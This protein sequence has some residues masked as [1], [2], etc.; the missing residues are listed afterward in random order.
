MKRLFI[1]IA[2]LLCGICSTK[3]IP[4]DPTPKKV[5]QPDGTSLTVL[6]RGDEHRHL[7]FT[8][9]G[10]PL[11]FN[12]KTKTY[13]Y[14]RLDGSK[15]TGSGLAAADKDMRKT[16]AKKYLASINID[17]FSRATAG[18]GMRKALS[19]PKIG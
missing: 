6:M 5:I 4:A 7:L 12:L 16:E 2:I 10:Y 1:S 15:I 8:E 3:A 14:A 9:D 18:S 17:A 19:F 13:E 11:F